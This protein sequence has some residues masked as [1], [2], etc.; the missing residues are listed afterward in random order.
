VLVISLL[1]V[2]I[3]ATSFPQGA[4]A[5]TDIAVNVGLF[6]LFIVVVIIASNRG[7]QAARMKKQYG[8]VWPPK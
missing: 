8:I 1:A 7:S 4:P 3:V 2:G 5:G 6:V